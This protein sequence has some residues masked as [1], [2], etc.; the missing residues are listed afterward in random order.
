MDGNKIP[1]LFLVFK[2]KEEAI[3]AFE[4][5]K[6]YKPSK[7]YI[8]ADGPRA[9]VVGEKD[10]CEATRKAIL[11]AVDW[12]CEV[13]TLFRDKNLGCTDAVFGGI[14]WLFENEEYGIIN[15][16]DVV[17][18][19]DFFKFCEVLLPKYKDESKVLLISSRNHSGKKKV[20]DEY[21]FTY[22]SNIWGWASWRR[23]WNLNNNTFEGWKEFNKFKIIRRFGLL[24]GLDIIRYYNLCSNPKNNFGSWDYTWGWAVTMNDGIC[25]CPGVNLSTNV[26]IGVGD[27]TNYHQGDEDPYAA[28]GL[29]SVQWPLK[30][31]SKVYVKPSQMWE[32]KKDFLRIKKIGLKKKFLKLLK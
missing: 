24:R 12:N 3:K 23:A 10:A 2:R 13:K 6:K 8:A 16:D 29:G 4:P 15:E 1:V 25:I 27:G 30:I 28:L 22:S 14:S 9:H 26:G 19:D 31:Q 32:E 17:L 18:A 21:I 11:D 7:L 5:I 20:S